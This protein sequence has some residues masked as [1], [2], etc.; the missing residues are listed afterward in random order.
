MI[1]CA[2]YI[3]GRRY[4][5]QDSDLWKGRDR[6]VHDIVEH[7]RC[8]RRIRTEGHADRMRPQGGFH[9]DAHRK[10]DP[11]GIGYRQGQRRQGAERYGVRGQPRGPL[12]GMRRSTSRQRMR[13]KR[14][15][16]RIPGIGPSGGHGCVPSGCG[17][18]RRPRGCGMRRVR[19]A[20]PQRVR[21]RRLRRHVRGDDVA[22]RGQ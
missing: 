17:H 20:H 10:E 12:R 6:Q 15:H 16:S 22:L 4:D 5:S 7:I 2:R 19:Y 8:P 18:I 21:P 3:D 1:K 9:R 11:H 14:H 13:R